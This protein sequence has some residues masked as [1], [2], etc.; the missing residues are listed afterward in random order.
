MLWPSDQD[1]TGC[2]VQPARATRAAVRST[3]PPPLRVK[4]DSDAYTVKPP[5]VSAAQAHDLGRTSGTA[6]LSGEKVPAKAQR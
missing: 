2:T 3:T 5:H 4:P 6:L 1:V